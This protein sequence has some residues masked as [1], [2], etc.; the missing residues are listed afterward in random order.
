MK[1]PPAPP[2]ANDVCERMFRGM[3]NATPE[4][5]RQMV[6]L[7]ARTGPADA[8]GRYLHWDD[9]RF[10][11]PPADIDAPTAW[12]LMRMARRRFEQA[13]PFVDVHGRPFTLTLFDG[14]LKPLHQ[15]DSQAHGGL[16]FS[17][18]APSDDEAR[19]FLVRSLIE[20]PF[21]SSLLEGAATT[22]EDAKRLIRDGKRPTSV[23]ERMVLNNYRAIEFIKK[24]KSDPLTPAL[25]HE[26]HRIVTEGT[27]EKPEKSGRVRDAADDISVVD[28]IDGTI[29]HRPPP[30]SE[31][32]TRIESLC[33]FANASADSSPFVHPILRAVILHFMLAYDHPYVDGNGRTARALFY[34]SVLRDGYWLLEYVSIS[35]IINKAP[36]AYGR[37]F[38]ETETDDA[39]LTYFLV[40][41]LNVIIEALDDLSEFIRRKQRSVSE[42]GAALKAR[43]AED[44]LNHRQLALLD[45]S[46]RNPAV[47]FTI[48]EHAGVHRVSYLTARSDLERLEALGYLEKSKRGR[49]SLYRPTRRPRSAAAA[50]RIGRARRRR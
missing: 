45:F 31:L 3:A 38:L 8:R 49:T 42:L 39:D 30:A 17:A 32:E 23:G 46:I 14:L 12:A 5:R 20:E 15:I 21:N 44:Q 13:T 28:D 4:T 9:F 19:S 27:L 36:T 50:Q 26:L 24:R 25:L 18:R 48:V 22:R 37:A 35:R 2:S 29:L 6:E 40:H 41:Q 7:I 33:D 34:W 1:I 16:Q 43:A 10:R 47:V 11:K